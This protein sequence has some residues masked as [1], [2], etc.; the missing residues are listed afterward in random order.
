MGEHA[1]SSGDTGAGKLLW[2]NRPSFSALADIALVMTISGPSGLHGFQECIV[3]QGFGSPALDQSVA[4]GRRVLSVEVASWAVQ[5]LSRQAC[6]VPPPT[7]R[8]RVQHNEPTRARSSQERG[9]TQKTQNTTV[10]IHAC[11]HIMNTEIKV[12]LTRVIGSGFPVYTRLQVQYSTAW[13]VRCLKCQ[14]KEAQL[15]N[16]HTNAA[17][18]IDCSCSI[19]DRARSC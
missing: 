16:T 11:H 18:S 14:T 9:R 10:S 1:S 19:A 12:F 8:F 3:L 15:R 2:L 4:S 17:M 5:Y 7:L 13:A 6:L